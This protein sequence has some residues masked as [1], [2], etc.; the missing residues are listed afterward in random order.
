MIKKT[1]PVSG[2]VTS[3]DTDWVTIA[4]CT[5]DDDCSLLIDNIWIVGRSN[6][7]GSTSTAKALHKAKRVSS[8]LSL[9]GSI[10]MLLTV[11]NG[12]E[13]G[14]NSHQLRINV[15]SDDLELQVLPGTTDSIDWRGGFTAILN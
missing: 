6:V 11:S 14:F 12:S 7:D 4:T 10:L 15:N 13:S 2:D 9:V 1:I 8:T 3:S 5:I